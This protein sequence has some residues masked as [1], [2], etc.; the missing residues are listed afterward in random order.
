MLSGADREAFAFF[1]GNVAAVDRARFAAV[2]GSGRAAG[3]AVPDFLLTGWAEARPVALRR[4]RLFTIEGLVGV[5]SRRF[6]AGFRRC[7]W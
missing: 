6:R 2:A 3:A 5:G 4:C 7:S 1:R